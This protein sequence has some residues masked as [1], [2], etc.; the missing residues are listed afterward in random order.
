MLSNVGLET[1]W[2]FLE[3]QLSCVITQ[4]VPGDIII[5]HLSS[6]EY[7]SIAEVGTQGVTDTYLRPI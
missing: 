1:F 2:F 5:M 4:E 7:S 6:L 3:P